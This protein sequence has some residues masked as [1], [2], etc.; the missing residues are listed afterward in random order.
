MD[1]RKNTPSKSSPLPVDFT[2]MVT[3][4]FI[5]N[6]DGG[7][8]ILQEIK[9][10]PANFLAQGNIYSDEILLVVSLTLSGQL[11]A[12]TVYA[13]CDFDPKASSPSVEDLLGACVDG[14]GSIFSQLL[15]HTNRKKL[16]QV[17]DES[18]A[19]LD[20]LP[21]EWTPVEVE[22]QRIFLRIDRANPNLEKMADDWLRAHDPEM[23]EIEAEEEKETE[24]LFVT[25]PK[26]PPIKH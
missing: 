1:R 8:K 6:F 12:T 17:A 21:F 22:R 10:T 23:R 5:S 25:G 18:L 11:S 14:I 15:S 9:S 3:D 7:I 26:R 4:V 20:G 24:D 2:R 19:A 16:E 13:S